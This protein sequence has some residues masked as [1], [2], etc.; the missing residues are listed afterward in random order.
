MAGGST[1]DDGH[2]QA[3][4]MM[5]WWWGRDAKVI[6]TS[7]EWPNLVVLAVLFWV[8]VYNGG[9]GQTMAWVEEG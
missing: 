3:E 9:M 2:G 7:R 1:D 4:D 6:V 5:M 8:M